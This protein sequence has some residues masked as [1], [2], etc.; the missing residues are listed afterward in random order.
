[1]A[2][3]DAQK[4]IDMERHSTVMEEQVADME[5]HAKMTEEQ[6][7]ASAKGASSNRAG[8]I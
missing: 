3:L 7:A 6:R 2:E 1:M 4:L 5:K 8:P